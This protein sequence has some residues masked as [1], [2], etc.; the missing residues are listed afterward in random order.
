MGP[1][2]DPL[3]QK[4]GVGP[5]SW[6]LTGLPGDSDAH[7]SLRSSDLKGFSYLLPGPQG[8]LLTEL[9]HLLFS[10]LFPTL[11]PDYFVVTWWHRGK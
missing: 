9:P 11:Q 2:P 4:L 3:N 6:A 8:Q 7:S 1:T 5:A 10:N